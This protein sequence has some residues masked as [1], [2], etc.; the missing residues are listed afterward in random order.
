MSDAKLKEELTKDLAR[1]QNE[2]DPAVRSAKMFAILSKPPFCNSHEDFAKMF[3][4]IV[5]KAGDLVWFSYNRA[6]QRLSHILEKQAKAMRPRRVVVPKARQEG[7]STFSEGIIFEETA[8]SPN[9]TGLIIAHK[10]DS[11]AH[12]FNM[13]RRFVQ[14]LPYKLPMKYSSKKEIVWA[15]PH[16][17]SIIIDSAEN[18]DAGRSLTPQLVHCSEVAYWPDA[19]RTMSGFLPGVPKNPASLVILESTGNGIGDWFHETCMAAEAGKSQF[20]LCFLPWFDHE[21]YTMEVPEDLTWQSMDLSAEE[22]LLREQ[23]HLT[24]G[25]IQWRRWMILEMGGNL[26]KFHQEYPATLLECF[27][28]TGR[29]VFR[30]GRVADTMTAAEKPIARA[31][32]ALEGG[33]PKYEEQIGG[34]L[35][36]WEEPRSG[37]DYVIG[38]DPGWGFAT[39]D[40]SVACVL[41]ASTGNQVAE[42]SG[43]WDSKVF[44]T[45]CVALGHHYNNAFMAVE[46]NNHGLFV[47]DVIREMG[48]WNLMR[49]TTYEPSTQKEVNKVGWQTS[50]KTRPVLVDY[51][52]QMFHAEDAPRVHSQTLLKQMSEFQFGDDGIPKVPPSKH[53]DELLAWMIALQAFKWHIQSRD[54]SVSKKYTGEDSWAWKSLDKRI[55]DTEREKKRVSRQDL[56]YR[57][58]RRW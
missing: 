32:I 41:D 37:G 9:K 44:A 40:N 11:S 1:I 16:N 17:S 36:V 26:D 20:E 42:L 3:L 7:V 52:V 24:K 58:K 54:T 8:T 5:D 57:V 21:E 33:V 2:P 10:R 38:V 35:A 31:S 25:Q 18:R 23:H 55:R 46:V 6:Q 12:I 50:V 51:A 29:P 28:A 49:R 4:K 27:L 48:Y 47:I 30:S 34:P 56:A 13:S 45:M 14:N 39:S 19:V 15:E 43:K 53:D 22:Q